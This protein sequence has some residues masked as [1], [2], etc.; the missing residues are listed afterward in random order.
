MLHERD[1]GIEPLA[2]VRAGEINNRG[3]WGDRMT[4]ER[5]PIRRLLWRWGRVVEY[6]AAR[7]REIEGFQE[8]ANAARDLQPRKLTG[9]P[10]DKKRGDPTVLLA[11]RAEELASRYDATIN[12]LMADCDRELAFKAA[13][14]NLID[15][16]P[17]E[18]Q[19]ILD[20]RYKQGCNWAF[21]AFKMCF[22]EIHVKRLEAE[23]ID[24]IEPDIEVDTK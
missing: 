6:C 15:R 23:A 8:M 20:L 22:S 10:S 19:K 16:L 9:M 18:H 3:D 4:T 11:I 24:R 14:D 7:Q 2:M 5:K 21:I 17:G 13:M 12:R 1:R